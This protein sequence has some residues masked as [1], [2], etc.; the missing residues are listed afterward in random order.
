[1][2]N[3]IATVV[4]ITLFSGAAFYSVTQT[5]DDLT[6]MDCQAGVVRA[7]KAIAGSK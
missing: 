7:C 3:L 2:Q 4:F 5:L 1:M 6:R